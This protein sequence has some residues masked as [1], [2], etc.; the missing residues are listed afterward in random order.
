MLFLFNVLSLLV[1]NARPDRLARG[2]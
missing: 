1:V 2:E